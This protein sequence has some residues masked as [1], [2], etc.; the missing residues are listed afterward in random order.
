MFRTK[1][2]KMP[3]KTDVNVKRH[4]KKISSICMLSSL[5]D[6]GESIQT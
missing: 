3:M 6:R 2:T 5:S 1:H 4:C